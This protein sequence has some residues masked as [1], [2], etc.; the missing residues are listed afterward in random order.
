MD[1]A[2]WLAPSGCSALRQP[3]S[4]SSSSGRAR[5][6]VPP[7]LHLTSHISALRLCSRNVVAVMSEIAPGPDQTLAE[8]AEEARYGARGD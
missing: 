1:A 7:C 6:G 5:E 4:A 8:L 3:H 2:G